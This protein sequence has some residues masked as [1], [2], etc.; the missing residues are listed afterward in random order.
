M[1]ATI[2]RPAPPPGVQCLVTGGAGFIGYHLAKHLQ[3]DGRQVVIVDNFK[4]GIADP[5][6][7]E[8]KAEA[9]RIP[10]PFR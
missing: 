7:E 3:E 5:F 10:Q 4:R 8:L 9:E 2:E 6:L 1:T